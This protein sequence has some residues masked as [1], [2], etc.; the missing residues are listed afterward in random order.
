MP[1]QPNPTS[2][3]L[4]VDANC[5]VEVYNIQIPTRQAPLFVHFFYTDV[6]WQYT[7]ELALSPRQDEPKIANNEKPNISTK[8]PFENDDLFIL[9]GLNKLGIF[10]SMFN[11]SSYQV[12]I[13]SSSMSKM[14]LKFNF[15]REFPRCTENAK[16]Y[17]S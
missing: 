16:V 2:K 5:K 15:C 12:C 9:M 10:R 17:Y 7:H 1:L 11:T 4:N 13:I 14:P 6:K 3:T 8:A